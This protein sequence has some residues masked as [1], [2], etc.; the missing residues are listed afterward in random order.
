LAADIEVAPVRNNNA[1]AML[2]AP[3]LGVLIITLPDARKK[4]MAFAQMFDVIG[5][6]AGV[7]SRFAP[8]VTSRP[9]IG[10]GPIPPLGSRP[11]IW[12]SDESAI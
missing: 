10:P 1:A 9:A 12:L 3:I 2:A 11:E 4:P 8:S 6:S 7:D 5:K